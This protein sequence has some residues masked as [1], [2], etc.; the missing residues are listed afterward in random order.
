MPSFRVGLFPPIGQ[1]DADRLHAF[2][3]AAVDEGVDHVCVGD[4]VSFFVGAGSDGL[5]MATV[6][7]C[8]QA[9][10]PVYVGLYLLP[11]RHPV[12][13]A[14]QLATIAQLAP[15]RLT[16]GVGI[17]GEDRHEIEVCGVDPKTRG[18][19][20]DECLQILRG[21]ANGEPVTFV[22]EFFSL[23]DALI[24]PAP[25]PQIRLIVGGRSDAAVSRAARL[26][27]GWLGIWVSPRRFASVRDQITLEASEAGRDPSVFEHALN[28]WC[29]FART[30]E[31]AR[32]LLAAQMQ[33]FYQMPF[34]PFERYSPYDTPQHVAEFLSPQYRGRLFSVQRDPVRRRRRERGRRGRRAARAADRRAFGTCAHLRHLRRPGCPEQP[35]SAVT[36]HAIV[37]E[38]RFH[39][40]PQSGHGGDTCGLLARELHGAGQVS[41][42]S[43]APLE[44]PL[45]IE[46][47]DDERLLLRDGDTTLADAQTTTPELDPPPHGELAAA[48]AAESRCLVLRAPSIPDTLAMR[49]EP[50]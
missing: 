22:G 27:D 20:M 2:L 44:R 15:G 18:R 10:L 33:A 47:D 7:L 8:A 36:R 24:V 17:G 34:E 50:R 29:G 45:T 23:K 25:S 12:L 13:V 42:C 9:E 30:H 39:G 4:H 49:S 43:P 38:R 3:A 31:S 14:R 5:T 19:R 32:D 6:L 48:Q 11:L 26:G 37:I 16:L 21:L 40:P 28:V 46:H 41:L 1:L 35:M